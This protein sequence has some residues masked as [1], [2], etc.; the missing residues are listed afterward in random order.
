MSKS[1][2]PYRRDDILTLKG[3][4]DRLVPPHTLDELL[5]I[6]RGK[7]RQLCDAGLIPF[8]LWSRHHKRGEERSVDT[9]DVEVFFDQ[10]R[11]LCLK[12]APAQP[13]S[14]TTVLNKAAA[15]RV[16]SFGDV[17]RSILAGELRGYVAEPNKFGFASMLFEEEH[18]TGILERLAHPSRSGK[19]C[20]VDVAR[21]LGMRAQGVHDLVT[22]ELLPE[23]TFNGA[24]TFNASAVEAFRRKRA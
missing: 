23:P 8:Y 6:G 21:Y 16:L 15:R 11:R 7:G 10:V 3:K 20:L 12:G 1:G 24:W 18:V 4:L 2:R 17:I 14:L 5:G 9:N 19:M 13:V 22:A